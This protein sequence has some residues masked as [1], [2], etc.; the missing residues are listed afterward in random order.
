MPAR[1]NKRE[2]QRA[3]DKKNRRRRDKSKPQAELVAQATKTSP[4][5]RNQ[6][7]QIGNLS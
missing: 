1:A 3:L 4:I 2:K 6:S 5:Y 7:P